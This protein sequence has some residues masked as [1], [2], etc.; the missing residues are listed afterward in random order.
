MIDITKIEPNIINAEPSDKIWLFWG[1]IDTRKTSVACRFK[2]H[3]LAAFDIGYKFVMGAQAVRMQTWSDFKTLVR[4]L[5]SPKA[6]EM[7]DI[8]VIDTIGMLYSACYDYILS[9]ENASEPSAISQWGAGWKMIRIEFENTLRKIVQKGYGLI[10]IGHAEE[11][12]NDKKKEENSKVKIDIDKRPD[13][14]I[15]QLADFIFFLNKE[16]NEAGEETVYA[17]SN[18]QSRATKARPR[19]FAPKF[20]FTYDNL[21]AELESCVVKLYLEEGLDYEEYLKKSKKQAEELNNTKVD[22][23]KLKDEVITTAQALLETTAAGDVQ[24]IIIKIFK[25][26]KI[27]ELLENEKNIEKLQILATELNELK[28]V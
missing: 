7:Y 3:L 5:D 4:Q 20:E 25:G 26:N 13:L 6:R 19:N 18:L 11:K 21:I 10:M 9:R 22:F 24:E 28:G 8:I 12:E 2:K 16:E 15:Q 14:I 27:S 17:Y 1:D 23:K